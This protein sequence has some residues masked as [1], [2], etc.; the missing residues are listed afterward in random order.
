MAT[1]DHTPQGRGYDSS[2]GYFHHANDYWRETTGTCETSAVG[3]KTKKISVV[4]LW[5]TDKPAYGENG[6]KDGSSGTS[7]TVEDYEEWKF[8]QHVLAII[9]A[10][11]PNTPLFLNY[12]LHIVHEPL[13][14]PQMYMEK[15][16]FMQKTDYKRNR[17]TYHAMVNFMD[18]VLGNV[19]NKLK[20]K[21][22]WEKT[23]FA[24]QSDNGGPSFS[25]SSHTANNWPLRGSKMSNW[26]GGTRVNG[27]I[28]GGFLA[29]SS[30]KMVGTT[31]NGFVHAADWY[32]TFCA[33]GGIGTHDERAALANLPPVDSINMWPYFSGQVSESPRTE[34]QNDEA[35]LTQGKY[36]YYNE[37]T[38]SACWSGPM[39][40]NASANPA[41]ESSDCGKTGCLFNI[42]DDPTEHK[43]LVGMPQFQPIVLKMQERLVEL[44]KNL[45]TPNRGSFDPKS[46]DQAAKNGNFWGPWIQ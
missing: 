30:P 15:F 28:S 19:T 45:F 22:M 20:Q 40:P 32:A 3:G 13:E 2:F 8:E 31:L 43:N 18:G 39:Y 35:V 10:H 46:C 36:K 9:E 16:D 21:G 24:F 37:S 34:F 33:L 44:N 6:T 17:Q 25:G 4:D 7:G 42:F 11:D 1:P 23:I 26:E 5:N 14:V 27:F 41:C 29:K 38:G 12:D